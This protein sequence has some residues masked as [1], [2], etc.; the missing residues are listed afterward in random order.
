M[1]RMTAQAVLNIEGASRFDFDGIQGVKVF[2]SQVADP[3][4]LNVIGRE[5]IEFSCDFAL[6]ESMRGYGF[7]MEFKCDLE[8][9]RASKGKAGTKIVS[10]QPVKPAAQSKAA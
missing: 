8:F 7:P 10:V 4:N 6:F 2:A 5:I 9:G 1:Q 3:H